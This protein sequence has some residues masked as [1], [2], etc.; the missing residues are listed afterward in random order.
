M[1]FRKVPGRV[2]EFKEWASKEINNSKLSESATPHGNKISS[3]PQKT[4]F[5]SRKLRRRK[6]RK[7]E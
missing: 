1:P 7:E 3:R 6:R 5:R 2:K 4:R